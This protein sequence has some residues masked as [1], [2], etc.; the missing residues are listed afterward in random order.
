MIDVLITFLFLVTVMPT[1]L[2]LLEANHGLMLLIS[3]QE[4][5]VLHEVEITGTHLDPHHST[6]THMVTL[7][8]EVEVV[9]VVLV[10]AVELVKLVAVE[11]DNGEMGNTLLDQP[12]LA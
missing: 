8:P 4:E 3:H 5:T 11:M 6:R 1:V 12:T 9:P 2:E 7:Q 10:L